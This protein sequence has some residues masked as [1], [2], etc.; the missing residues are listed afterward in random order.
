[1]SEPE[2]VGRVALVTWHD[3]RI[4]R[5]GDHWRGGPRRSLTTLT[6]TPFAK[7]VESSVLTLSN[8]LVCS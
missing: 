7:P 6:G 2:H 3:V 4:H 5:Q 1:M 8:G